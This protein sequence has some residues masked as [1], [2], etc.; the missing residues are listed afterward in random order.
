MVIGIGSLKANARLA[1]LRLGLV[2]SIFWISIGVRHKA[3]MKGYLDKIIKNN[4]SSDIARL[5][6]NLWSL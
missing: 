2:L 1:V 6:A 4:S 3:L 5:L